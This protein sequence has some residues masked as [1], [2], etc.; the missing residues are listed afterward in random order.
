[1][2]SLERL[3]GALKDMNAVVPSRPRYP[4]FIPIDR[5][6]TRQWLDRW[7]IAGPLLDQER[8]DRLARATD[9]ELSQQALDLARVWNPDLP[10]DDGEA[11]L[12]Q[13]RLFA[14]LSPPVP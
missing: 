10:G 6:A 7:R 14:S 12:C 8:W 4:L 9:A 2:A 1:M 3:F 5:D 11:L 13:Q